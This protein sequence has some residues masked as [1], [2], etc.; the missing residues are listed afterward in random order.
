MYVLCFRMKSMM[1]VAWFK[2]HLLLI[3]PILN[4]KLSP[5]KVRSCFGAQPKTSLNSACAI[6]NL[7]HEVFVSFD[8][9]KNLY[10]LML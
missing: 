5:L 3:E 1:D 6:T 9:E 7:M 2:S 10:L 4:Y 8:I